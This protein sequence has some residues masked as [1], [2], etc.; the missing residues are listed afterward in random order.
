MKRHSSPSRGARVLVSGGCGFIGSHLC[1]AL[2]ARDDLSALVCV[3]NLWTGTVDNIAH[4]RDSRFSFVECDVEKFTSDS[5]FDE[6]YHLASP[7][8]PQWYMSD[9]QRTI[10]ANIV[11]AINL[12][13]YLKEDGRFCYTS[14]SEVYGDPVVTPQPETY[15][16]AV[17][18]TGPRS[19]Y[20][21][22]KRV[23]E[24]LLFEM[25]RTRGLDIRV[26]RLFNVYGPRTRVDDGRAVSNFISQALSGAPMTI[27]GD[28]T[29]T[30]S[31]GYIDDI[32]EG[33]ARFFWRDAID[34]PG[35]L[36]IGNNR[37][38]SVGGVA[39]YIGDLTGQPEIVHMPS[40]PDDP[41]NRCP[42]LTLANRILPGW[43]CE[44]P[45]E[46][47]VRRTMQWFRD[48]MKPSPDVRRAK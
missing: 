26:A 18:C 39:R 14:T 34:Y 16:G 24:S 30:R 42:D 11:G 48:V 33:L 5:L 22:S 2:L 32:V 13:R 40:P 17:S 20:D 45:Y 12:L 25:R 35:P 41:T 19:S 27:Y 44:V 9:P 8:S 10:S 38:I 21:E 37:E 4:V 23:T 3:D 43:K 29:Q 7:A 1:D 6:V 46:D 31:W 28:G 47:G 36:N 15:L